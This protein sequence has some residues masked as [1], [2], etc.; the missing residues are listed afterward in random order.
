[1]R[2]LELR[3]HSTRAEGTEHLSQAGV[4][5]ARRVGECMGP[6]ARV[7]TSPSP[8]TFETAI[9]MGFA[10]GERYLPVPLSEAEWETLGQSMPPGTPFTSRA[11]LM[12]NSA[13]GRRFCILLRDQWSALANQLG[14]Q[15]CVLVVTHGGYI[16]NS[17]VA[18]LP[19]MPHAAWGGNFAHCEGMRLAY[20][21][22]RF[23]D[24]T[25]LRVP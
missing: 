12:G 9:A 8:W 17:A 23:V 13:L 20:S 6:F 4:A 19:D 1:M 24:G 25:A 22:G 18:C 21:Q 7:V 3:R 10:V 2:F 5:L 15:E 14:D 11:D 16:D